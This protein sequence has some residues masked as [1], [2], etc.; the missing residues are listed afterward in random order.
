MSTNMNSGD[1][2]PSPDL[3]VQCRVCGSMID[4]SNKRDQ[5][6]VKCEYCN[7]ATPIRSPPPGQKYIRCPC[8]CLLIC[9]STAQRISCPRPSCHKII[10]LYSPTEKN[11]P[12]QNDISPVP[13]MCQVNCGHC[14]E[15]FL[16][17]SLVN[18]L[19]RCPHCEKK[20]SVGREFARARGLIFAFLAVVALI[21][22]IVVTIVTHHPVSDGKKGWIALYAI[23]YLASIYFF[24][25]SVYFLTMKNSLIIENRS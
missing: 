21:L 1:E 8:N 10:V 13:G 20:S 7:E 17:N 24:F 22:A 15:A 14:N 16:F 9:R 12:N 25:R 4:I 11:T 5:H 23:L 6:V 2:E 3:I 18:Q 19:A